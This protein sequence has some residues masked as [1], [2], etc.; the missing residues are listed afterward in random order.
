M[1][2]SGAKDRPKIGRQESDENAG[3]CSMAMSTSAQNKNNGKKNGRNKMKDVVP[4]G[5]MKTLFTL[6]CK[7]KH[8]RD[9]KEVCLYLVFFVLN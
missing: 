3:C 9:N 6:K 4:T 1:D 8:G 5:N 2:K 7:C